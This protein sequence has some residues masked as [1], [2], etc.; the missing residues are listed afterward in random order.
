[1]MRQQR[2]FVT[3]PPSVMRSKATKLENA[4]QDLVC[5]VWSRQ[6]LVDRQS[7]KT[8]L[9]FK[10]PRFLPLMRQQLLDPALSTSNRLD[11]V[12]RCVVALVSQCE[13][14]PIKWPLFKIKNRRKCF[15]L[16][17]LFS[18]SKPQKCHF[19]AENPLISKIKV[20]KFWVKSHTVYYPLMLR[21][22]QR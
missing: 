11:Q 9:T 14:I 19:L 16:V 6:V 12:N 2:V 10:I 15:F 8:V 22:R 13:K 20:A 1:M 17:F 3:L 21:A 18:F 7:V 4:H 5:A